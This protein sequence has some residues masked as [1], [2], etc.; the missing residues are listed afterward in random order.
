MTIGERV[1]QLR[2]MKN[3]TQE[4]L[5]HK[6]GYKNKSSVAHI[7]NGRD[8]P[9]SMVVKLADVL[10][11]TPSYLMGW[12]DNVQYKMPDQPE[13]DPNAAYKM[14]DAIACLAPEQKENAPLKF[15]W[16]AIENKLCGLSDNEL[17]EVETFLDFLWYK[18]GHSPDD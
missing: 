13:T 8:I 18:R 7:E 4:E 9:R 12:D 5:A 17:D 15:T 3:M 14:P 10:E 2:E 11:T 16:D 6:L 1:K